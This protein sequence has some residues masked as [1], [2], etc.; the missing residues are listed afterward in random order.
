[1]QKKKKENELKDVDSSAVIVAGREL[2]GGRR[3]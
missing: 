3:G 2:A 1:M